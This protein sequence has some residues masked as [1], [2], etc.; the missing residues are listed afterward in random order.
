MV[1]GKWVEH[2]RSNH[3]ACRDIKPENI[4]LDQDQHAKLADFGWSNVL[5]NVSYR[6]GL[7]GNFLS[8]NWLLICPGQLSAVRQTTWPQKWSVEKVTMKVWTCGRWVYCCTLFQ[9]LVCSPIRF[10]TDICY[11]LV[12][13]D[14]NVH[15][16]RFLP[17]LASIVWIWPATLVVGIEILR[18]EMV[19]GKSPF[20]G[21]NQDETCRNIL[22]LGS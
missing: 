7:C 17:F 13:N 21:S 2:G 1:R 15:F 9:T 19:V 14:F 20:G 4:L 18:Y 12:T 11:R 5:E 10:V 6:R 22:K 3:L 8:Q 16:H